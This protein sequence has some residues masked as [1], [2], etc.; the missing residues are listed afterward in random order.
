MT[1]VD[2]V[3][4]RR[5]RRARGLSQEKLAERTGGP[6]EPKIDK[7]TISRLERGERAKVRDRTVARL[8][9]ALSV[10][11]ADLTGDAP[12]SDTPRKESA[13]DSR[14]QLNVRIGTAY[15]NALTLVAR[16]YRIEPSQIVE[17]APFL[18]VWAAEKSLCWRQERLSELSRKLADMKAVAYELR[19]LS[20]QINITTYVDDAVADEQSSINGRDLFGLSIK[21]N[22]AGIGPDFDSDTENPFADFLRELVRSFS[23]VATF[24]GWSAS[25]SPAY[26]VCFEEAAELVGGERERADEILTGAIALNEMP[27]ELRKHGMTRER[28]EWVRMKAEEYHQKLANDLAWFDR[29]LEA[30]GGPK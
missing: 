7:Q 4:L 28:A 3:V 12:V 29:K 22:L 1:K 20:P 10:V 15:R 21:L 13:P 25:S 11:P 14:S 17:L 19:H 8:A 27:K 5:L 23:N 6:G 24:G 26:R 18:F 16:R 2:P 30:K 9:Q